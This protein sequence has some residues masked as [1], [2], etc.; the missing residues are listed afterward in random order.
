MDGHDH[1][2]SRKSLVQIFMMMLTDLD[3]HNNV[4]SCKPLIENQQAAFYL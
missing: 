1:F 2:N 3:D 4:N